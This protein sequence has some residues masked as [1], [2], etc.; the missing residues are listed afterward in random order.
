MLE[1]APELLLLPI[2]GGIATFILFSIY[3]A[4]REIRGRVLPLW[5][6]TLLHTLSF[7]FFWS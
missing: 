6:L 4:H 2:E 3:L 5:I 7:L 1:Y